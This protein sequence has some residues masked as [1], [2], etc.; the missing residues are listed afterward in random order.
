MDEIKNKVDN[1]DGRTR[2]IRE[3]YK[4]HSR[5]KKRKTP[6]LHRLSAWVKKN[7]LKI[8][9]FLFVGSI[10]YISVLF[11]NY[12]ENF[13]SQKEA[14]SNN[15]TI[16]GILL[17]MRILSEISAIT[18]NF[19]GIKIPLTLEELKRGHK[20][21]PVNLKNCGSQPVDAGKGRNDPADFT[22]TLID[23]RI[24]V[25]AAFV[26]TVDGQIIGRVNHKE[27]SFLSTNIS[28]VRSDDYSFEVSDNRGN[29]NFSMQFTEPDVLTIR[30]CF[31]GADCIFVVH[32]NT[33]YADVKTGNYL[34]RAK[35]EI[36]KI[37]KIL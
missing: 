26:S 7:P 12:E 13:G 27:W 24:Y 4:K 15:K 30:G 16:R 10:I 23:D 35:S 32:D 19:G 17:P 9:A 22:I 8:A 6:I 3:K 31:I 20:I 14:V 29:I 2:M 21:S 28:S 36:T 5:H 37:K 25:N 34:N 18:V 11:Y 33:V 1:L